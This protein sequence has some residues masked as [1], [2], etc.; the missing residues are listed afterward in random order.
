VCRGEHNK[1]SPIWR[2]SESWHWC[3][4]CDAYGMCG[5]CYKKYKNKI[6]DH[7]QDCMM[8]TGLSEKE[9]D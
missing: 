8:D 1:K 7:E 6:F 3:D 2:D 9:E 5:S 4:Y